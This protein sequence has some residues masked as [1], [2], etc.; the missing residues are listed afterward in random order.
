ME[1]TQPM[2][3][4]EK[5]FA[6]FLTVLGICSL[7]YSLTIND[8]A[9][10]R[11][12][13]LLLAILF[14][15]AIILADRFPIHLARGTKASL[16]NLPI[17]M[18]AVLLP[19]PLAVLATGTGLLVADLL[20]RAER[21]LLLKDMLSTAGQW[22][23]TALLGYL[24]VHPNVVGIPEIASTYALLLLCAFAFLLVDSLIY[25]LSQ[26]LLF[27][28]PFIATI[29]LVL[30]EGMALEII[31][32]LTAVLG[33][34]AAYQEIWALILLIVPLSITYVAFKNLKETR[35]ETVQILEDM[36]D[37]VDL[38]DIYTGGH[39]K[40][41]ADLV[42]DIL[43][44]LKIS[45]PEA[46]LIELAA[47]LHDIGK[48]GIPDSILVKPGPLV[49]D[50]MEHMRTHSEKGANLIIKYKDFARGAMIIR[51]HHERW[52][53]S[54]YPGGLKEH[55]IPFGAR[56]IAVADSFDAMTSDRP[57]RTALSRE[58]AI[59]T[60]LEGRGT[61]W[62]ASVVNA[63]VDMVSDRLPEKPKSICPDQ[64]VSHDLWHTLPASS[65]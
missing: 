28:E 16:I 57:Y 33:T 12:Q 48:I 11:P 52:D 32:Y 49:P 13:E 23:F 40:R 22:M 43:L 53:G 27:G 59:Q 10:I 20:A 65:Q 44:Q 45:G 30:R 6:G 25:S 18:S 39:S 3:F 42:R 2:L 64:A 14:N 8:P 31:Q 54:G 19:A 17:F 36:A 21:G 5:A 34:L 63:F 47:R 41:V 35:R 55:E 1:Q 7:A 62:D 29:K 15:S 58:Q 51:H 37:T 9:E 46:T 4:R 61:Q 60:L 56:I 38:R 24:I 50:E 26:S